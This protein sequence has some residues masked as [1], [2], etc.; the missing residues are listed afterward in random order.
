MTSLDL[1]L[2]SQKRKRIE[3]TLFKSNT[4]SYIE[5]T[6]IR[7][8]LTRWSR[9]ESAMQSHS[10]SNDAKKLGY[11]RRHVGSCRGSCLGYRVLRAARRANEC[12]EWERRHDCGLRESF[13]AIP[14]HLPGRCT[15]V[16]PKVRGMLC[17][18]PTPGDPSGVSQT[19]NTQDARRATDAIQDRR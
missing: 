7:T 12:D 3:S 19:T 10:Y 18:N 11:T 5:D 9:I 1:A 15:R 16:P 4:V 6:D 14:R 2:T 17:S 8:A 13:A